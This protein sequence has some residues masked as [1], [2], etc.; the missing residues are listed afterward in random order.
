MKNLMNLEGVK[1]LSKVEQKS[2]IG[3]TEPYL[4]SCNGHILGYGDSSEDCAAMCYACVLG[5][6]CE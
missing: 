4:C 1:T 5:G 3:G 6:G 2:V